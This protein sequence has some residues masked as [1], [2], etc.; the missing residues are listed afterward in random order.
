VSIWIERLQKSAIKELIV[1][2]SV[3]LRETGTVKVTVLSVAGLLGE[4]IL[5]I[6]ENQ[7]VS[8]LFRI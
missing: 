3:P 6:H 5:R 2:D 7:S 4:A 8:S 1:T